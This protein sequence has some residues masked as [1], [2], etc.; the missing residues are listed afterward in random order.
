MIVIKTPEQVEKIKHGG[1]ILAELFEIF[2]HKIKPGVTTGELDTIAE[3]FLLNRGVK[4]AFKGY[5]GF[6]ATLCVSINEEVVHGIPS[7]DK[8]LREGDIVSIDVGAIHEGFYSDAARTYPVG[9]IRGELENLIRVTKES[10]D[11]AISRAVVQNKLFD[12]SSSVEQYVKKYGYTVVRDFVGHGIGQKM[13][14]DPQIPNFGIP[15]TGPGLEKGMVFAIEPMVNM[16]SFE[17]EVL[18]DNWTVVTID[19]KPSA[20]FEDTI[21]ITEG[22]PEILTR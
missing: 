17:V 2:K 21:V 15:H 6:P 20:H 8:I 22:K 18:G 3:E 5:K 13:H 11:V 10:L 4:P 12:I 19:R 1:K 14:E 16:G 9:R 7:S